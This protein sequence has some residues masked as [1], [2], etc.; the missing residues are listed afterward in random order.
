MDPVQ[1]LDAFG[2]DGPRLRRW[3]AKLLTELRHGESARSAL[4][5]LLF[6]VALLL[7]FGSVSVLQLGE[8][9]ILR[10]RGV[11]ADAQVVRVNDV[12]GGDRT[13]NVVFVAGPVGVP[14][15]LDAVA[16]TPAVGHR[17][18]VVYDPEHPGGARDARLPLSPWHGWPMWLFAAAA[19]VLTRIEYQWWRWLRRPAHDR[20]RNRR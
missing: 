20:R 8:V 2:A 10:H 7:V 5:W 19:G 13:A 17:V 14:V 6:A 18:P 3:E 12:G 1:A 9:L 11:V 16:G 4:L 15:L